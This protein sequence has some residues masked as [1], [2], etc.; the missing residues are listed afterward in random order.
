MKNSLGISMMLAS[1]LGL[2]DTPKLPTPKA[3]KR[4][5]FRWAGLSSGNWR[6]PHQSARE[7]M[8]RVRQGK[9]GTCYVHGAQYRD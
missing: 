3:K 6:K 4:S 9:A 1:M 2:G 7:K 5:F 8:R